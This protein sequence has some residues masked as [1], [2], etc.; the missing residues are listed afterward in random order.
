[1]MKK[2]LEEREQIFQ[3]L[4]FKTDNKFINNYDLSIH[5]LHIL[6][7]QNRHNR[8]K[9]DENHEHTKPEIHC[10]YSI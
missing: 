8:L 9:L 5:F 3:Q 6:Y 2:Y 4:T 1:M 10:M 7:K